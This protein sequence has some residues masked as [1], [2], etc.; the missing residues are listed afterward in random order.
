MKNIKNHCCSVNFQSKLIL[1]ISLFVESNYTLIN[2]PFGYTSLIPKGYVK[3][4]INPPW[5]DIKWCP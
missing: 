4:H 1:L 3:A 5:V 2:D